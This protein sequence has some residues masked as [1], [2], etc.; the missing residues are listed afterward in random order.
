M[1]DTIILQIPLINCN[2]PDK[3]RFHLIMAKKS[4]DG[5]RI[6][7]KYANNPTSE[8]ARLNIY[9]PMLTI[10]ETIRAT[11]LKI[12]F[13]AAKLLYK[14]NLQELTE[15]KFME[16]VRTLKKLMADMGVF[17]NEDIIINALVT[18]FHPSK[19]ILINGGYSA[20]MIINEFAKINLTEKMEFDTKDYRNGGH[21]LQ[22]RAQA[23]ALIF[24]DKVLD[25]EKTEK[26]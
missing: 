7:A 26:K 19:N 18:A 14:N 2:I 1:L 8:D 22:L 20:L 17:V 9:K 6:F 10:I 23:H 11:T 13:S 12:E 4:K 16:V 24:Y 25:L 3:S 21:G 15:T 5:I